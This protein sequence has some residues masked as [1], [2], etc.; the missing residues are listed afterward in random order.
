[1]WRLVGPYLRQ[2]GNGALSSSTMWNPEYIHFFVPGMGSQ[3]YV[4]GSAYC[5]TIIVGIGDPLTH[6]EHWHAITAAF[7]RAFPH[8]TYAHTG[9]EFSLMLRDGF[10]FGVNDMGAETNILAQQW[11]YNKKT[12]TIRMAARDART[13]G[14]AVRELFP[15]DLTPEVCEQL[16]N[17]TGGCRSIWLGFGLGLGWVF[18]WVLGSPWSFLQQ[19]GIA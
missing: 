18:G 15:K 19:Q 6:R 4:V 14:T 16:A 9:L 11:A 17:V 2:Y 13:V 1:V 7:K 5:R 8:A 12:R 10:G 3:P